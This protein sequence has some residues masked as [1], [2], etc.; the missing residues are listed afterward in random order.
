MRVRGSGLLAAILLFVPSHA[1]AQNPF[2][3]GNNATA[4]TPANVA[5][6]Q[7]EGVVE[8]VRAVGYGAT[9]ARDGQGDPMINLNIEGAPALILF[10][11]CDE[12]ARCRTLGLRVSYNIAG[13]WPAEKVAQWNAGNRF[14]RA[15]ADGEGDPVLQMDLI[16][17]ETGIPQS[18]FGT[19]FLTFVQLKRE[20]ERFIDWP[21]SAA[22]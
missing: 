4:V 3:A 11:G 19:S 17:G 18:T 8:A 5:A 20:M 13:I 1:P 7:P 10:Y 2:L 16:P 14:A 6:A 22:R 12:G 9:L 15:W 21:R